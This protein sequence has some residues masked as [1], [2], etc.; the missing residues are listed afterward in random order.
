MVH[1]DAADA[2]AS[3][4][5]VI[6][7]RD[8]QWH[9]RFVRHA[10]SNWMLLAALC[11]CATNAAPG[12]A[13]ARFY[14]NG[15]KMIEGRYEGWRRVPPY[16]VLVPRK[17]GHWTYWFENGQKKEEGA[18]GDQ[19][20]DGLWTSWDEAGH[21]LSEVWYRADEKDGTSI[22]YY[23]NGGQEMQMNFSAGRPVGI[24]TNWDTTGHVTRRVDIKSGQVLE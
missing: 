1:D 11:A 23:P 13:V 8:P 3:H 10:V 5:R 16:N 20:R 19:G 9:I 6:D 2:F 14:A 17:A 4:H 18:Y 21:K 22:I 7:R 24:W 12:H 15:A